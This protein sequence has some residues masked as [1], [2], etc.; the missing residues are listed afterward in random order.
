MQESRRVFIL[1]SV[2]WLGTLTLLLP[3][4]GG[5]P[6]PRVSVL[7][8]AYSARVLLEDVSG[9]CE[10]NPDACAE[11]REALSLLARKLET[12]A[13]IVSAV[14]AHK[15]GLVDRASHGTLTASDLAPAWT[16]VT[17]ER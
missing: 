11:S 4:A 5:E 8:T 10:R 15:A 13:G 3:P 14:A 16:L 9:L 2:F 7:H 12:G 1:R 6:A 17:G